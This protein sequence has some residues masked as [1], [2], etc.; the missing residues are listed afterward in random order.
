MKEAP[1]NTE[2]QPPDETMAWQCDLVRTSDWEVLRKGSRERT[3]CASHPPCPLSS[4]LD[5]SVECDTFENSDFRLC[6][7]SAPNIDLG[8]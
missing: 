6:T 8:G 7:R 5:G 3:L 2:Y 1:S 4:T